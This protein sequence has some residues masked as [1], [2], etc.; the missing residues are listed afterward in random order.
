MAH[1]LAVIDAHELHVLLVKDELVYLLEVEDLLD[2]V[3]VGCQILDIRLEIVHLQVCSRFE[4]VDLMLDKETCEV[5]ELNGCHVTFIRPVEQVNQITDKFI[6]L[7]ET[8]VL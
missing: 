5:F 6:P 4:G 8:C 7:C 3:V 2:I 1:A